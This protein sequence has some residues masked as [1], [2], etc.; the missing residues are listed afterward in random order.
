MITSI[1]PQPEREPGISRQLEGL[2]IQDKCIV[3]ATIYMLLEED[4]KL[5]GKAQHNA[6]ALMALCHR[7]WGVAFY[8]ELDAAMY[9]I[10]SR[11]YHRAM[12]Q[13]R[14]GG[15]NARAEDHILALPLLDTP[16]SAVQS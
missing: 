7:T 9:F 6:A 1:L 14:T 5:I 15:Y 12:S 8:D 4:G 2:S 13:E 10:E 16:L 11:R 3:L